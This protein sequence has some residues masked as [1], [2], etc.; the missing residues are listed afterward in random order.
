MTTSRELLR[1]VASH[2]AKL[3]PPVVFVGG[4][5][6]HLL[7]SDPGAP[8]PTPTRD[9]DVIV[10]VESRASY[11]TRLMEDLRALGAHE[12]ARPG[13]PNC[14]WILAGVTVDVMPTDPSILGFS[15]RWYEG[16]V[17]RHRR[18]HRSPGWTTEPAG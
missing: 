4:I 9:V 16:A 1:A 14:R 18:H 5:A 11:Y 17:Q 13:A 10:S 2:L 6:T 12:D 3:E 15:S 7:I 8:P